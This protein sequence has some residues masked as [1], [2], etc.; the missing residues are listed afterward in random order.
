MQ[1]NTKIIKSYDNSVDEAKVEGTWTGTNH[2]KYLTDKGVDISAM[3]SGA[4]YPDKEESGVKGMDNNPDFHGYYHSVNDGNERVNYLACY[5]F[6]IKI[7]NAYGKGKTYTAVVQSDIPGLTK[8]SYNAIRVAFSKMNSKIK[9]YK[10]TDN[11]KAFVFGIAMHTATDA[12]AHSTFK[13]TNGKWSRITHNPKSNPPAD[14]VNVQPRRFTMAY[15]V[16]RNNLYRYKGKRKDVPVCH[17]FH[18]AGDTKGAYYTEDS[19]NKYYRIA[20]ISKNA[21]EVHIKDTNVIKHY[22]MLNVDPKDV[23]N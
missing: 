19:G 5:R 23:K 22:K 12:F 18:A 14:N 4:V 11:R 10:S 20:N 8:R 13:Y 15:R 3:K 16:E 1:Q 6:M 7:G 21:S 17:D 2:L 9:S